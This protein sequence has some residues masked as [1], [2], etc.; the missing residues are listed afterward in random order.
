MIG[1]IRRFFGKN[2]P[3]E[4]RKRGRKYACEILEDTR[5]ITD[6]DESAEGALL[7]QLA[8]E[9]NYRKRTANNENDRAYADGILDHLEE[10]LQERDSERYTPR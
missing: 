6:H 4:S 5:I 10:W 2:T 9:M 1:L 3:K 7:I 8:D